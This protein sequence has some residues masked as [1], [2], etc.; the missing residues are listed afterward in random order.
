MGLDTHIHVKHKHVS[1]KGASSD[2]PFPLSE[3]VGPLEVGGDGARCVFVGRVGGIGGLVARHG[4]V[5]AAG[6]A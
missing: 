3:F 2:P 1:R 5:G 4:K 6:R